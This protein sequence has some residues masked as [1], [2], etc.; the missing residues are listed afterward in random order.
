M[1]AI[2]ERALLVLGLALGPAVADAQLEFCNETMSEIRIALKTSTVVDGWHRIAS[3]QCR[4]VRS[5]LQFQMFE[6]YQV[7][8]GQEEWDPHESGSTTGLAC[9]PSDSQDFRYSTGQ[10]CEGVGVATRRVGV[11]AGYSLFTVTLRGASG[12]S[13]EGERPEAPPAERVAESSSPELPPP[14]AD[15][16][17]S[18]IQ[19]ARRR[20]SVT[21]PSQQAGGGANAA[22]GGAATEKVVLGRSE[23]PACSRM[24]WNQVYNSTLRTAQQEIILYATYNG[25]D[26]AVAAVKSQVVDCMKIGIAACGVSSALSNPAA[27]YPTFKTAFLTCLTA[28][29][30]DGS[31]AQ[32]VLTSLGSLQ[33]ETVCH[34]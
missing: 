33:T 18:R 22:V 29:L 12:A 27:C 3:G 23:M 24:E 28:S 1:K 19:G 26:P 6:Y 9:V 4:E 5:E 8:Q 10:P 25:T 32:K 14:T 15:Q 16:L 31:L 2:L 11:P 21:T 30:N 13:Y 7:N 20:I 17:R 34:W